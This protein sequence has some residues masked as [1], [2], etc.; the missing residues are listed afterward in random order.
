MIR[1]L[2]LAIGYLFGLFQTSYILAQD[3]LIPP[4]VIN[5]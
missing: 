5:L 4:I 3:R 2:C 1:L